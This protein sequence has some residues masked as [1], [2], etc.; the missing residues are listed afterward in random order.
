MFLKLLCN[1]EILWHLLHSSALLWVGKHQTGHALHIKKIITNS[2][3]L[4]FT[5]N[6]KA[7]PVCRALCF[8]MLNW[9][10]KWGRIR[11]NFWG[12]D[13]AEGPNKLFLSVI[14]A[15]LITSPSVYVWACSY[16]TVEK[17]SSRVQRVEMS[18]FWEQMHC[19]NV[20]SVK[21]STLG[22]CGLES[23]CSHF[24]QA[25]G[26]VLLSCICCIGAPSSGLLVYFFFYVYEFI[27]FPS[28]ML[29]YSE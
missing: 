27:F 9:C 22:N 6:P 13:G 19:K 14:P 28:E 1:S 10:L 29:S 24:P 17:V 4:H 8:R 15:F 21:G 16:I 7:S 23:H 26:M 18:G 3:M 25:V 20:I 11:V 5:L 12:P 2:K